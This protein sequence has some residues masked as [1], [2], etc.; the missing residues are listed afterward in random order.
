VPEPAGPP[1]SALVILRPADRSVD[2][3]EAVTAANVARHAPSGP[4]VAR[5]T[6]YF[7]SKGFEVGPLGGTAFSI[8]GPVS[9]FTSL[10]GPAMP[11]GERGDLELDIARLPADL[12]R[13]VRAVSFS[14]PID[15]GPGAP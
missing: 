12:R 13:Q 11:S 2:P 5:L 1:L 6:A 15:F 8:T 9:R 10:F 3:S 14:E 4:A 7:R